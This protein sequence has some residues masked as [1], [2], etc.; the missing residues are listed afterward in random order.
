MLPFVIVFMAVWFGFIALG[1]AMLIAN[2]I[3][4]VLHPHSH[5][6]DT[7]GIA[8][9]LAGPLIMLLLGFGLVK[10]GQWLGR[11]EEAR[12]T[13]FLQTTFGPENAAS[14]VLPPIA[15]VSKETFARWLIL[16]FAT[17]GFLSIVSA[18]T[19]IS[20]YEVITSSHAEEGS[21]GT[22]IERYQ[23]SWARSLAATSGV[24]LF[25][26]AYG[27]WK[28]LA[29][30]WK[31][32]FIWIVLGCFSFIWQVLRDPQFATSGPP[33]PLILFVVIGGPAVGIYWAVWWY[34]KKDYFSN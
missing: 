16:F 11:F 10:F 4:Q 18:V 2:S 12:M 14:T 17:L 34:K 6:P 1:G 5:R 8:V 22:L 26:M 28:R 33:V 9:S 7:L 27:T 19:G 3:Q 15:P 13:N 20:H 31:I 21:S 25:F 23:N 29:F 24:F 30:I 32:G